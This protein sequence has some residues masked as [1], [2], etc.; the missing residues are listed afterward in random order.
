MKEAEAKVVTKV[1]SRDRIRQNVGTKV[2]MGM[3]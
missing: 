2:Q 3:E 1:G